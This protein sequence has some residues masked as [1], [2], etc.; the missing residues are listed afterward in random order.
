[1]GGQPNQGVGVRNMG[2]FLAGRNIAECGGGW[3]Y[4]YTN[5]AGRARSASVGV[6]VPPDSSLP[7]NG[8]S[9]LAGSKRRAHDDEAPQAGRL[10]A[11]ND[12]EAPRAIACF[13]HCVALHEKSG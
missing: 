5:G 1:M 9:I 10:E 7:R 2:I 3:V 12:D 8:Q 4:R 13:P 11:P 6:P